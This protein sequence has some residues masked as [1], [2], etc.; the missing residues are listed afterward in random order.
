MKKWATLFSSILIALWLA[1]CSAESN[2]KKGDKFYA[3][4]EYFEAGA[5][6][7]KAYMRTKPKERAK[8]GE[9]AYKAADCYRRI[10]YTSRAMG[11]YQNAVRYNY[12]DSIVFF[13]LAE[14]QRKN[15]DY[16][17]AAQNYE[18]Y[19]QYKPDDVL[20]QNGL[21]GCQLAPIWKKHSTRY[22]VKK[23]PLLNGRRSDYCPML[24]G[25]DMDILYLTSTRPQASGNE[26]SGITGVKPGDFFVTRKDDKGKW[27]APEWVESEINSEYDEGACAFSPDGQTMYFTRCTHDPEY[28]RYAQIY[29]STRSDAS[30]SAPE[31]LE[32]TKD[33]LSSFAHPTV[34]PDGQWLY[35][36]SDMPGGVGGLDI[37]RVQLDEHGL[38]AVDNLGEPINTPGN[39]M[40]PSF[41]PNGELYFSSDGHVGMG[42]L[43]LFKAEQDSTGEWSVENLKAPMNSQGDDF[44]MTFEGLHNRGYFCTNRGDARGWDHIMSFECPEVLLTVKGW[45]YEKDGYE[46]PNGL[47]YMVGNDGTN[48]KL[49]VKGDG[50]FTQ[51]IQPNVDY[52]FLGTCKGF[53]N[54]K[55]QLRVDTSSV[56]KEYV[57]QFELASITAPVLVDNVFYAFDSAELTD[58]STLALDSLVILMEDNP[59][60]TIELSS[61]CDYRGND[62]YNERLSQ[63]RAESVVNYLIAHGVA[64]DRLTPI[65][66]GEKRP[67]VIRKRL[68]ERYPFL[69]E[70]DTLTEA[71]ILKLPEEQQEICNALN[72]RTEFRVLRTTYGLFDTPELAPASNTEATKPEGEAREEE[73]QAPADANARPATPND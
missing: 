49:S 1:G 40:F 53:L 62:A 17:K 45:V 26:L 21:Q 59:N 63:R 22:S 48:L 20:A 33:T 16:K 35:F 51:E 18:L 44:G 50:S 42:G 58:S 34:S 72:R 73:E 12:P 54:H 9:R 68:T 24:T 36:V 55:E 10:N 30:W 8:R 13:Y 56:S 3:I 39:E 61:H 19:L 38:G 37:W 29:T 60:I 27:L 28:P 2:V 15:G 11:S 31:P 4:G 14:M 69:H 67:K 47:V 71:F 5:E 66:Y 41:R 7:R 46:L 70:N 23:E 32:I 52:V 43:D 57:L 6:Y 65:G 64:M 25:D